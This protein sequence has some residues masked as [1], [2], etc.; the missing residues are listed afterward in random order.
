MDVNAKDSRGLTPLHRAVW[1]DQVK[2]VRALL[3]REDVDVNAMN[4]HCQSPLNFSF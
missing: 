3:E 2:T 1:N 4:K